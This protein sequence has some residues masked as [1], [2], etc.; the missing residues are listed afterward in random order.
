MRSGLRRYVNAT[1]GFARLSAATGIHEKSLMRMLGP[2]GNPRAEHLI[3]VV[4]ALA[5]HEGWA[6]TVRIE[7]PE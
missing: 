1:I 2:K 4:A 6:L 7:E 5:D 3:R